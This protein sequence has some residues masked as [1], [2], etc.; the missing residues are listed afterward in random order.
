MIDALAQRQLESETAAAKDS[1]LALSDF[2][3]E[4]Q[5]DLELA[6]ELTVEVKRK[7]ADLDALRTSITKPQNEALRKVNALFK[8]GLDYYEECEQLL[9]SIILTGLETL[10]NKQTAALAEAAVHAKLGAVEESRAAILAAPD[11]ALPANASIREAWTYECVNLALVPDVFL[12]VVLDATA[13]KE[14]LQRGVREIPGLR[15]F[16]KQTLSIRK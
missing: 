7:H 12:R 11:A 6:N 14:A 1:L 4:T 8:P 16:V 15:I 13:V 5:E 2:R 3:V 10:R 9:K